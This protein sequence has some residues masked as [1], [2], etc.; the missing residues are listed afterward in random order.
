MKEYKKQEELNGKFKDFEGSI[1]VSFWYDDELETYDVVV[2]KKK[3]DHLDRKDVCYHA[4][5]IADF[6]IAIRR[7]KEA[8]IIIEI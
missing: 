2:S 8:K 5:S 1:W 4:K 7:Y 3:I 6:D